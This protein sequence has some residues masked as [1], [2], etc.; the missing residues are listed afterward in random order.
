MENQSEKQIDNVKGID[1]ALT[2][3]R[4]P[5]KEEDKKKGRYIKC[6]HCE[7]TFYYD[8]KDPKFKRD[9]P[10]KGKSELFPEKF[11]SHSEDS[12]EGSN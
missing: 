2:R 1:G 6:C 7:K 5:M 10:V 8:Y 12:K 11:S 9:K 4:K 3:G